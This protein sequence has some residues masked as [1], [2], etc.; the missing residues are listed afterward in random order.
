[1]KR[2]ALSAIVAAAMVSSPGSAVADECDDSGKGKYLDRCKTRL[3]NC[4]YEH[5]SGK[6]RCVERAIKGALA[7]QERDRSKQAEADAEA[8]QWAMCGT[9]EYDRLCREIWKFESDVCDRARAV[10]DV[11]PTGRDSM[12]QH[13]IDVYQSYDRMMPK[14][15]DYM[16]KYGKCAQAPSEYRPACRREQYDYDR[17][18]KAKQQFQDNWKAA[19]DDFESTSLPLIDNEIAKLQSVKKAPTGTQNHWVGKWLAMV[20]GF[21]RVAAAAPWLG[22]YGARLSRLEAEVKT[23]ADAYNAAMD[24]LLAQVKCP[25]KK[26]GSG[27]FY[28]ILIEHGKA[29]KEPGS[30]LV[31]T[32]TRFE[33]KGKKRVTREALERLTHEDQPGALCVEQS[34]G[35]VVA[36]RIFQVTFRRTKPDGGRWGEWAFYSIGGGDLMSCK[37]LR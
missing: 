4:Q 28:D 18:A 3:R 12:V 33:A 23:R 15:A 6:Q 9:E 16:K 29:T 10:P 19:V 7:D 30:T 22:D 31:E 11:D 21:Q 13:W 1:M 32:V 36:C 24:E 5:G 14:F 2:F 26:K 17:C 37:N 27:K 20:S 34:R 8:A 25:V 35:D